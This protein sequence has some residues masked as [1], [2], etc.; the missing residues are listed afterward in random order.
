MSRETR[1]LI[2]LAGSLCLMLGVFAPFASLPFV[3]SINILK[4]NPYVG[5]ILIA[6]A[7]GGGWLSMVAAFR[8]M[9]WL[10]IVGLA[11]TAFA[12]IEFE[13]NISRAQSELT[14]TLAGNP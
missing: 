4:Y 9:I 14:K 12:A 6:C 5:S 10:G 3:G 1:I 11:G 13:L 8:T 7:L 2:G